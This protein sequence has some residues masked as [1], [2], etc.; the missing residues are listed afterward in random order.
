MKKLNYLFLVFIVGSMIISSCKKHDDDHDHDN[1]ITIEILA[2]GNNEVVTAN[3]VH[4]QVNFLATGSLHEVEV[5]IYPKDDSDNKLLD[6]D[7]HLH[8]KEHE[9]HEDLDLSSFP[10]GTVF[11]LKAEATLSHNDDHGHDHDEKEEKSI[12][13]SIQ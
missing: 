13:F 8:I 1:E 6:I 7:L 11:V 2:P 9:V 4:V 12:E 3:D 10:V 5:A